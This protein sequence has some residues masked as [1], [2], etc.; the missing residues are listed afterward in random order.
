MRFRFAGESNSAQTSTS[1][2]RNFKPEFG[3]YRS[4]TILIR[5]NVTGTG[6]AV[7]EGRHEKMPSHHRRMAIALM[8]RWFEHVQVGGA[9]NDTV[10]AI[11]SEDSPLGRFADGEVISFDEET[12]ILVRLRT[13][14]LRLFQVTK[15]ID[16]TSFDDPS[17]IQQT[18]AVGTVFSDCP[19][20]RSA[21][22]Q[23]R[24]AALPWV[25]DGEA[26]FRPG[27]KNF[28]FGEIVVR[29]LL[30][31]LP[32]HLSALTSAVECPSPGRHHVMAKCRQCTDVRRYGASQ[33]RPAQAISLSREL[34]GAAAFAILP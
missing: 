19:P 24:H 15:H 12:P 8:T 32:Y 7:C 13:W 27:M 30:G 25:F 23:L 16:G 26:L 28:G 10:F 9:F 22:A 4:F 34:A 14:N 6:F 18:F 29:Q 20:L 17:A 11:F 1:I 33:Q 5:K 31:T 21:R 2:G 3:H